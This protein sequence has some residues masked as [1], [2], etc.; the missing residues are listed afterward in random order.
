MLTRQPEKVATPEEVLLGLAAQLVRAAPP[1]GGVMARVTDG[2]AV[3]TVL[4][5]ASWTVT[6]GWVGMVVL[7]RALDGEVVKASLLAG[8]TVMVKLVLT[9]LVSPGEAAVSVYVPGLSTRHPVKVA[10]P[11]TAAS[12]FSV[13]V[14]VAVP[15][16]VSTRVTGAVLVV[17]VLPWSS[18]MA[19]TGWVANGVP[20]VEPD[21]S[22]VK[23]RV[24]VEPTAMVKPALTAPVR[25]LAVAVR[26]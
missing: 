25:P 19:T 11:D 4:P 14:R 10:T 3:V 26:V 6:T 13:Q 18:W 21:G 8:P 7:G 20:P 5:P 15:G 1:V 24:V 22:V 2:P 12:G 17:T 9:A 23:A 16:V